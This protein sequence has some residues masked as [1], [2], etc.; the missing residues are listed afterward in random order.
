MENPEM[1]PWKQLPWDSTFFNYP[2]ASAQ[3]DDSATIADQLPAL[4]ADVRRNGVKLLYLCLPPT[5]P[6]Q[7]DR[8][9]RA[10]A[11]FVGGKCDFVKPLACGPPPAPSP[12][13]L[14]C[15]TTSPRLESLALQ[16]GE[17]S[18]FRLDAE[19][20]QGEFER[21]YRIWLADSLAGHQGACVYIAGDPTGPAG[22]ITV[23]PGPPARIGLF[24]VAAECRHQGLGRRLITRAELHARALG[25]PELRV[26]TQ[27]ENREACRFYAACGFHPEGQQDIFHIW[28]SS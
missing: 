18:R 20:R 28:L 26:A 10:G 24:A 8:L 3:L 11:R 27:A 15:R 6:P 16:S 2:V 7:R 9:E 5:R 4:I 17:F 13:I 22:F 19:F 23:A 12:D 21:L 25:A 14:P 1:I